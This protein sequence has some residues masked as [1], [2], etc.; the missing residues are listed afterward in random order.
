VAHAQRCKNL[1]STNWNGKQH[2][3]ESFGVTHCPAR[4]SQ[5][6]QL[7]EHLLPPLFVYHL[8]EYISVGTVFGNA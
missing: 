2:H 4:L 7:S 5:Q 8:A 3:Q 1:S 6:F